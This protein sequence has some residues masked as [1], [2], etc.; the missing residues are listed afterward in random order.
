M[1]K[2]EWERSEDHSQ[3]C[4]RSTARGQQKEIACCEPLGALNASWVQSLAF[5]L[6]LAFRR[7]SLIERAW[8]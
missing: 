7:Y 1:A 6:D 2:A 4:R 5:S 3:A 8:V